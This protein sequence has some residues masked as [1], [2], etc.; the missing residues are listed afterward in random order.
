MKGIFGSCMLV[1]M[2]MF[3]SIASA[4]EVPGQVT[5]ALTQVNV[6]VVAEAPATSMGTVYQN[7]N[8]THNML[9]TTQNYITD[10]DALASVNAAIAH[11]EKAQTQLQNANSQY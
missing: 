2:A 10:P 3:G 1:S 7:L 11:I 4:E 9:L 8:Q 6:K 5:N